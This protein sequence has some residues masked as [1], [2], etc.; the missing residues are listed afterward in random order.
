MDS[1]SG[2]NNGCSALRWFGRRSG[3]RFAASRTGC[4]CWCLLTLFG[5][6]A[7]NPSHRNQ[8]KS[9]SWSVR[10]TVSRNVYRHKEEKNHR[11]SFMQLCLLHQC[12]PFFMP[13]ITQEGSTHNNRSW[14]V[15]MV[16][17]ARLVENVFLYSAYMQEM[18]SS[19]SWGPSHFWKVFLA[20][21][22]STFL[23][24]SFFLRTFHKQIL[25]YIDFTLMNCK[26]PKQALKML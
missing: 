9:A 16:K 10:L 23:F 24:F 3:Y 13:C 12:A 26:C 19:S 25:F 20:G 18:Q 5:I 1:R 15:S 11:K 21:F 2:E 17:L 4:G 22:I 14:L 7:D 8:S 6:C